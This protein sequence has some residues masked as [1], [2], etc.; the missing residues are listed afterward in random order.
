M[1]V[2]KLLNLKCSTICVQLRVCSRVLS[3][4]H[5]LLFTHYAHTRGI[6]LVAATLLSY[7]FMT[8][9]ISISADAPMQTG[10]VRR[11]G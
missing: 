11:V 6:K 9:R 10:A 2:F 3:M 4:L 1:C 8:I 7:L 5:S